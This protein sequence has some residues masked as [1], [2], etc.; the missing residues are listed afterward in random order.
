MHWSSLQKGKCSNR[1]PQ[2]YHRGELLPSD[3]LMIGAG[4]MALRMHNEQC[5]LESTVAMKPGI[6]NYGNADLS[7]AE[8][9]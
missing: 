9:Q 5:L 1:R 4:C 8:P 7:P 2:L 3:V 6:T